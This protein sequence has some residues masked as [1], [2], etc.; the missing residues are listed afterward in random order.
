MEEITS[1]PS[2]LSCLICPLLVHAFSG[3]PCWL[4]LIVHRRDEELG[5]QWDLRWW[6]VT[7]AANAKPGAKTSGIA[8]ETVC[9][10]GA[11]QS[12]LSLLSSSAR[13]STLARKPSGSHVEI[14]ANKP[15][16]QHQVGPAEQLPG[17][18]AGRGGEEKRIKIL[19]LR[20][21]A[22]FLVLRKGSAAPQT[23][24]FPAQNKLSCPENVSKL[25][26][27]QSLAP[28]NTF[29]SHL[30]YHRSWQLLRTEAQHGPMKNSASYSATR[31]VIQ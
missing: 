26:T 11:Q 14:A 15:E 22:S 28:W 5:F 25:G 10:D 9:L 4:N 24:C 23:V 19:Q 13:D 30:L 12:L 18:K 27:A 2:T 3:E 20:E 21:A 8:K 29:L 31:Q 6:Q 7:A 17:K 1:S 16:K